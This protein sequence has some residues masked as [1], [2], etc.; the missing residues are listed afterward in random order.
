[1]KTAQAHQSVEFQPAPVP[2]WLPKG[3]RAAVCFSI[4]D[5]HPGRST[6]AYEAG[7]DLDRGQLRHVRWLLERHPRLRATLFTTA[8]WR[9]VSP[10]PTRRLLARLPVVRDR[11]FLG[12]ALPAGTMRLSRHP[13]FVGYLK[14]LPRVEIG[15]HG[16]NHVARGASPPVEFRRLAADECA[17]A[18]R[19]CMAI[20]DE[21][22]LDYVRGMCPPGWE[23]SD[24]LAGAMIEVGLR[25]VASARDVR[26]PVSAE[27]TANMSGLRGVSLIYPQFVRA[28]LLHIT[29][30]F[31]A[32]CAFDR[33]EEI[34]GAGGLL[35]V[36]A[37]VIKNAA[38]HV[39]LD[40]LDELYRNYLDLLF[41]RLEDVYGDSLWW[42]SMGEIADRCAGLS[43]PGLSAIRGWVSS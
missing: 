12:G 15:L 29:T 42:T 3:K 34:V 38:G 19:E 23:L 39:A 17:R 26:T 20:F 10:T 18:L 11:L 41:A 8:D 14:R 9:A 7:G 32:T 30:N 37:H 25:F 6:D 36:K 31:Q 21:A 33:A 2:G 28:G 43:A 4:D 16:L 5:V 24:A 22:G 40:G 27:A 1:M 13:E 35:A